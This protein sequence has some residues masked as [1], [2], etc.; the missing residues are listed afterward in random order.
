VRPANAMIVINIRHWSWAMRTQST[1]LSLALTLRNMRQVIVHIVFRPRNPVPSAVGERTPCLECKPPT[2]AMP[3]AIVTKAIPMQK[4]AKFCLLLL[5]AALPLVMGA[6][7]PGQAAFPGANGSISFARDYGAIDLHVYVM[8]AD[9]GGQTDLTSLGSMSINAEPAWSPDGKRI[10]FVSFRDSNAEIYVMSAD[11]SGQTRL[12]DSP[13]FDANPA[14]SPDGQKIAF[15]SDRDSNEAMWEIYL[16]NADGSGQTRLTENAA[17]D[18]N[19]DW[20]PDGKKIAF[21]SDRDG[22]PE[23]YVMN[24]DGSGQTNLTDNAAHDSAPV[25]SPDGKMIAFFSNRD[26]NPEIYVMNA[27]GSGQTRLTDNIASDAF[28]A[29]SP[30]GRRIAF[31]SDRDGNY[32]VYVMNA[33]GGGQAN[34]TNNP[35]DD[36]TPNWQPKP[37]SVGVLVGAPPPVGSA[38]D[39]SSAAAPG[40]RVTAV[41]AAVLGLAAVALGGLVWRTRRR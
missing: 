10:A 5:A 17:L 27:D 25:W 33:D 30:D 34:L 4:A 32:E 16:M 31:E 3:A 35:L 11:G 2:A 22:N 6:Q 39:S 18:D 21:S 20:S 13:G 23:I 26:G 1:P 28:P 7:L 40:L 38:P 37:P 12:T 36:R 14:W 19:P 41:L 29:W 15:A 24:A 9:G 8:D